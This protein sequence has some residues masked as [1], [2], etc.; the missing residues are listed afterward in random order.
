MSY[1]LQTCFDNSCRLARRRYCFEYRGMQFKL[2]QNNPR[3]WADHLLT[4]IS[5]NDR[6]AHE[7]VFSTAA[8]FLSALGWEN[9]ARIAV[10]EAGGC[11]W[12]DEYSLREAEPNIFTFP[13]IPFGGNVVG[14]DL[15]RLPHI[16]TDTQRVALGLFREANASNNDYLS[17]LFFWQVLETGKGDPVGFINKAY[18]KHGSHLLL[19]AEEPARLPLGGRTLGD[20]LLDDCRHAIA[21]IRRRPG[22]AKL[23]VDKASER[24]RLALSSRVIKAF[25]EHY[26]REG[27]GLK[28]S[29]FLCYRE[30]GEIPVYIDPVSAGCGQYRLVPP[31]TQRLKPR[32]E[33]PR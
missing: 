11:G 29:L 8:E 32:V 15:T 7:R 18:R 20:Y 24:L 4:I 26:I 19:R 14:Y 10:W 25:A 21:H 2:V 6:L 1:L 33:R 27:L 23:D 12:P 9:G 16:E 13:R 31:A 22:K 3:K 30:K 17:F 5:Q 28:K